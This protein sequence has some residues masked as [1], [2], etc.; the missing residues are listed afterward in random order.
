MRVAILDHLFA[1]LRLT[2][3]TDSEAVKLHATRSL[4][5]DLAGENL[6]DRL[7]DA[8]E[9]LSQAITDCGSDRQGICERYAEFVQE[10]CQR[11]IDGPLV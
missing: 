11:D 7:K 4:T 10:W 3:P 9:E 5:P 1:L 8:N 2:L 6:I